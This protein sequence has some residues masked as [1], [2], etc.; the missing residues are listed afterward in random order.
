M[1]GLGTQSKEVIWAE[2]ILPRLTMNMSAFTDRK[3]FLKW[4]PSSMHVLTHRQNKWLHGEFEAKHGMSERSPTHP[5][6]STPCMYVCCARGQLVEGWDR[7]WQA[8]RSGWG[9]VGWRCQSTERSN[10]QGRGWYALFWGMKGKHHARNPAEWCSVHNKHPLFLSIVV[11]CC[12]SLG[13]LC[14][15]HNSCVD[16]SLIRSAVDVNTV[17][18]RGATSR[19][20]NTSYSHWMPFSTSSLS[21]LLASYRDI[22]QKQP[23][24]LTLINTVSTKCPH[25]NDLTTGCSSC[26]I[27]LKYTCLYSLP[28]Q[29]NYWHTHIG[30]L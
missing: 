11:V 23:F 8:D 2:R 22:I 18:Y 7:W 28:F 17:W 30:P 4:Y 25:S 15:F 12:C 13:F 9:D 27:L 6:W 14:P 20:N 21:S 1:R 24:T 19:Q 16:E 29:W 3:D 26:Q 5:L 10:I